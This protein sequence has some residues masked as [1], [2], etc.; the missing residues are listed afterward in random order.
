MIK[1][2]YWILRH[3]AVLHTYVVKYWADNTQSNTDGTAVSSTF[4]PSTVYG[5][6][7][8]IVVY[9]W[10]S[11]VAETGKETMIHDQVVD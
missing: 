7:K 9:V 10:F 3:H 8:L 11:F 4:S 1:F 2:T 6:A 5:V